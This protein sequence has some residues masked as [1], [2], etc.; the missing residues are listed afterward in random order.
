MSKDARGDKKEASTPP[1]KRSP[2]EVSKSEVEAS[3]EGDKDDVPPLGTLLEFIAWLALQWL[4][5]QTEGLRSKSSGLWASGRGGFLADEINAVQDASIRLQ[6]TLHRGYVVNLHVKFAPLDSGHKGCPM[7]LCVE[8]IETMHQQGLKESSLLC[9][10]WL[11][12]I[13]SLSCK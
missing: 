3:P 8:S 11:S 5:S 2:R 4:E 7:C 6:V 1:N 10:A 9:M 12:R 13:A